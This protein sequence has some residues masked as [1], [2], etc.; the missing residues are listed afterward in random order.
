[1]C[2]VC[3]GISSSCSVMFA[4]QAASNITSPPSRSRKALAF[5]CKRSHTATLPFL[6]VHVFPLRMTGLSQSPRLTLRLEQA[7]NVVLAHCLTVSPGTY[8]V[9]I[10][11]LTWALDVTDDASRCVVHELHAH[12]CNTTTRACCML[13]WRYLLALAIS[14]TGAAEHSGD[15][16]QLDGDSVAWISIM[17]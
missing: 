10:A 6:L 7:Q 8:S 13:V 4:D 2:G 17:I 16:D 15:L 5:V 3:R 9:H 14:H 12:L 11:C 1:M